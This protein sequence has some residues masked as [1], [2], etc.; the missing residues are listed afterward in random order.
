MA[1]AVTVEILKSIGAK[2]IWPPKTLGKKYQDA[3]LRGYPLLVAVLYTADGEYFKEINDSFTL[4][5]VKESPYTASYF[6][7]SKK[8]VTALKSHPRLKEILGR[9]SSNYSVVPRPFERKC[10]AIRSTDLHGAS[11]C[12]SH[13]RREE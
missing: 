4:R 5:S 3:Q 8:V 10:G 7:L 9:R 1:N 13:R 11:P 6:E 12:R 2:E